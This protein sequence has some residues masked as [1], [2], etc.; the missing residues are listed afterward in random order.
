MK[1]LSDRCKAYEACYD[2]KIPERI[3]IILR[4]DGRSF[5]TFTRKMKLDR[6]LDEGFHRAMVK[7][8]LSLCSEIMHARF[9]YTQS[10]EIS[11]L[12]YPKYA[13]SQAWFD[14]RVVKM[15]TA[16]AAL[17][18][19]RFNHAL[20]DTLSKVRGWPETFIELGKACPTFDAHL[21]VI[22]VHDVANAFLWRQADA[23]R[24]SVTMHA[25]FHLERKTLEGIST[26]ERIERLKAIQVDWNSLPTWQKWGT[27]TVKKVFEHEKTMRTRWEPVEIPDLRLDKSFITH[28]L[29]EPTLKPDVKISEKAGNHEFCES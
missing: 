12:I 4:L 10:D 1:D 15:A 28:F 22:P 23:A 25:E 3:P 27:G 24:N 11:I 17:A 6:P 18:S 8:M 13:N 2:F 29:T 9:G 26:L 5:H 7:T 16:A 19:V 21:F 14:N 20:L